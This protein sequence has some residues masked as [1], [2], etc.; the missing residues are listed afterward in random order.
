MTNRK[1]DKKKENLREE[2]ASCLLWSHIV[3]NQSMV[4]VET[5]PLERNAQRNWKHYLWHEH[6]ARLS[7]LQWSRL[8]TSLNLQPNCCCAV[9]MLLWSVARKCCSSQV[10]PCVVQ[11][12]WRAWDIQRVGRDMVWET[13]HAAY[14]EARHLTW[15]SLSAH[16]WDLLTPH[17]DSRLYQ[18]N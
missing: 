16:S 14:R 4:G 8:E 3:W 5:G 9:T 10:S 1:N 12:V 18:V 11:P 2:H 17:P 15:H 13:N 6:N 7:T